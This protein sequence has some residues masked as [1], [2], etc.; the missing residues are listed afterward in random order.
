MRLA[1]VL[2]LTLLL[3]L[4]APDPVIAAAD[5]TW[6][7][8]VDGQPR[9]LRRF[10]PPP[11][12]WLSG[13][14][15]VD[16]A[17]A[18]G[19][20]VV[21]AGAGTINYAGQLA[22]RGV[23][24]IRHT[25]GLRTTYLPVEPSV[26]RGQEVIMGTRLGT[27]QPVTQPHC[28]ESCLH[29]GLL[30]DLR[31]L[32]PLLLLGSGLIRLLPFWTLPT[33]PAPETLADSSAEALPSDTTASA[34]GLAIP[35]PS[36]LP[37]PTPAQLLARPTTDPPAQAEPASGAPA[38]RIPASP[39][40]HSL[41]TMLIRSPEPSPRSMPIPSPLALVAAS[42]QERPDSQLDGPSPPALSVFGT[43]SRL[44]VTEPPIPH[45]PALVAGSAMA[46]PA[47]VRVLAR[48]ARR[49]WSRRTRLSWCRTGKPGGPRMSTRHGRRGRVWACRLTR[50]RYVTNAEMKRLTR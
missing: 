25:N 26:R 22:G 38:Q 43:R 37:R 9:V 19:S 47:A 42:S 18:P 30:R 46:L 4:A 6:R 27:L 39:P 35:S 15:G 1:S 36:P 14:R 49:E 3:A 13:H 50:H 20:P 28:T 10:F 12:P 32:D 40:A 5:P 31:Y 16:L 33:P 34:A 41:Q 45:L 24:S 48:A 2:L 11:A 23:V 17:V 7:W 44:A 21:A 8:P 29:W